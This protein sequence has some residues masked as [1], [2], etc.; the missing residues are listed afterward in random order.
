VPSGELEDIA[1][2]WLYHCPIR[3]SNRFRVVPGSPHLALERKS[4]QDK[5]HFRCIVLLG[6]GVNPGCRGS[7]EFGD[8]Q[9]FTNGV[10]RVGRRDLPSPAHVAQAE[11]RMDYFPQE[12]VY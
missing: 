11:P 2:S 7:M 6:S 12:A 10:Q 1:L 9:R 4:Y 3:L 8:C 5:R